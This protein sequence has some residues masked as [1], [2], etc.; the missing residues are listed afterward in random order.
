MIRC[1][2]VERALSRSIQFA[3]AFLVP[4]MRLLL[5]C[6]SIR[7]SIRVVQSLSIR[8]DSLIDIP[9]CASKCNV[10]SIDRSF[11]DAERCFVSMREIVSVCSRVCWLLFIRSSH[12][13]SFGCLL[14]HSVQTCFF[15]EMRIWPARAVDSIRRDGRS[16]LAF[17]DQKSRSLYDNRKKAQPLTWTQAVGVA[18]TRS[19]PYRNIGQEERKEDGAGFKG[20]AEYDQA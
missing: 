9:A 16:F 1:R 19:G 10:R 20:F 8:R 5:D 6:C 15:T 17:I 14:V 2:I 13:V 7:S 11:V 4:V 12:G 18:T 3:P